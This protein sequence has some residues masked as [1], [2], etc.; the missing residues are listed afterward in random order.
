MTVLWTSGSAQEVA[1]ALAGDMAAAIGA[2]V[3]AS[4]DGDGTPCLDVPR[5]VWVTA[6]THAR[7]V[8]RMDYFDWLSAVDAPDD[9][10]PG[11]VVVLH[12]A[13]T[14]S[15]GHRLDIEPPT[16][17]GRRMRRMLLRTRV[18]DGELLTS[19]TG[20]WPG[21]A[22]HER[23]TFE[24]F[25]VGFEGFTDHTDLGLRPLLLPEGFEGTP[26]RKSFVLAARVVKPWPGAK[27]PGESESH[28]APGRRKVAPPGVPDPSWGP[29]PPAAAAPADEPVGAVDPAAADGPAEPAA[30]SPDGGGTGE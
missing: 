5:G 8:L 9:D 23:E 27:E 29:R 13:A 2:G 26:L 15:A 22:W 21:A 30:D 1:E 25:G 17:A 24:M 7:H 6:A 3:Q 20:L 11:V 10:P 12:V 4:V 18:P 16:G 14:R 28:G 19:L